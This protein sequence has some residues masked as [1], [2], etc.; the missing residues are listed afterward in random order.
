MKT[1][2]EAFDSIVESIKRA[3]SDCQKMIDVVVNMQDEWPMPQEGRDAFV[4]DIDYTNKKRG[5]NLQ[6]RKRK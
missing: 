1:P 3:E 5:W 4:R 2:E 6:I